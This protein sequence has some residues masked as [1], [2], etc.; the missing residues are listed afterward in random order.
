MIQQPQGWVERK[1]TS[2][3]KFRRRTGALVGVVDDC[4]LRDDVSCGS[5]LCRTC[6]TPTSPL[7]DDDPLWR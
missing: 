2:G 4:Y 6:R 5:A 3:H 1:T 7:S